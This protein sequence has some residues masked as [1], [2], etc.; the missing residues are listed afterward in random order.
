[1]AN[2]N[3]PDRAIRQQIASAIHVIVQI[4][5]LA[6]GTRK[7]VSISEITGLEGEVVNMQEIFVFERRGL[8]DSG[9]VKGRFRATGI[10]PKFCDRL[11]A[12]GTR[13]APS[14]FEMSMEV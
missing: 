6:D 4:S 14:L 3:I 7:V 12:S 8:T 1:M 9:Q 5:R 11:A 2:L 10:R 13:L